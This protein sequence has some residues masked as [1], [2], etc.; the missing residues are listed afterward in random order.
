[1]KILADEHVPPAIVTTLR[2][3]GHDVTTVGDAVDFGSSDSALL[4]FAIRTDRIILSE[5]TDF[6]G[7]DPDLSGPHPGVL[8]V[9]TNAEPGQIAAAVRRIE[10][11]SDDLSNTILY[12][13]GSWV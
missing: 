8:S 5:D 2:A 12:V 9:D 7:A 11:L 4:D 10:R 6:L 13:P 3:D 1:M